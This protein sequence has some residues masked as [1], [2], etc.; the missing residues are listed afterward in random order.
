MQGITSDGGTLYYNTGDSG[1]SGTGNRIL[2]NLVHDT[3]SAEIIDGFPDGYGGRGIYLDNETAG[4]DVE[5]NVVYNMSQDVLWMS[6]GPAEGE[7]PNTFNNNIAAYGRR[8]VFH[9]GE[10]PQG[11]GEKPSPRAIVTNNIFYFDRDGSAGFH[12]IQGCAYS[13]GLPFKDFLDFQGNL[14]WRTDGKFAADGKAFHVVTNVPE[15]VRRCPGGPNNWTYMDFTGWQSDRRPAGWGPPGGMNLDTTGTATVDPGFGH[16]GQPSDYLLTKN[17]VAGFDYTKTNDTI[18]H[19]GRNHPAIMPPPVP[20]TLP[21][22][23]Y[24][25]Y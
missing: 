2:N 5:N 18:R 16:T 25:E 4:V 20:P 24:K 17:P 22:Y 6:R 13:C 10:W 19:A 8:S 23:S 12:A 3:T 7:P 11:C 15:N 1:G 9:G 21:S 14:W